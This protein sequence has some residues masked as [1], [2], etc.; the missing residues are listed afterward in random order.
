MLPPLSLRGAEPRS[1][2][3]GGKRVVVRLINPYKWLWSRIRGLPWTYIIRDFYHYH[4]VI[5]GF[6]TLGI[7]ILIGH[8]FRGM[9]WKEE[10]GK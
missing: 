10:E 9:P 2:L 6:P 4:P 5:V 1:N 7:G 3:G 8:L